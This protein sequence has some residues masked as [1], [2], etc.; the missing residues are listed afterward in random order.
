MMMNRTPSLAFVA[1]FALTGLAACSDAPRHDV[2]APLAPALV[3]VSDQSA[4]TFTTNEVIPFAIEESECGNETFAGSG[5][6][7]V[8][9][10]GTITS[11]GHIQAVFHVNPQYFRVFGLTT[12]A[13]YLVPGMLHTVTNM[14]GPA[15]LT[16]TLVNNLHVIGRGAVPDFMLHQN[17]HLTIN[18]NGEVTAA[19]DHFFTEC[20]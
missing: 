18:A 15:P 19:F 14:N 4:S 17:V 9:V 7:H 3:S 13:E 16:E 20:R 10:H 2:T 11:S 6:L 1:F 12:G 8:L 5:R